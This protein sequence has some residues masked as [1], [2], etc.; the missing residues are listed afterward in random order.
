MRPSVRLPAGAVNERGAFVDVRIPLWYSISA[1]ISHFEAPPMPTTQIV[2]TTRSPA[3]ALVPAR[4]DHSGARDDA[5]LVELWLAGR[6][7]HTRRAYEAD[8][9]R[10]LTFV[11][12]RGKGLRAATLADLQEFVQGLGGAD[13]TLARR[14][15]AVKSLL[16]FGRR[17]GYLQ[18]DVGKAVRAPKVENRLAERVLTEE[19]V[20]RMLAAS[21]GR[22]AL[23]LRLLYVAG[24]RVSEACALRWEHVH[25]RD[26]GAV[27]TLHGKGG[28]TRHVLVTERL[29]CQLSELRGDA[30]PEAPVFATRTGRP[31]H[32]ANVAKTVRR[33]AARAGIDRPVS[34]HWFRHAHAS[35]ALDRG[36]PIH[37]VQS[38]LGHASVATTG[39]YLHARPDDGSARYL[40]V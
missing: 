10:F 30:R 14:V 24:A 31:L 35:H 6:S 1:I 19:E 20:H 11:G 7:P 3:D 27:L 39:R 21:E 25:A 12:T 38:T 9:G 4:P 40:G 2:S 37:L 34:P 29:S 32:P 16:S 13:S 26:R 15:A 8:A 5:H 18:F 17:T 33:V 28:K 23:L 22:D 36:A